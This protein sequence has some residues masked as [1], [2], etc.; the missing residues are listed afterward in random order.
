MRHLHGPTPPPSG[1]QGRQ[2]LGEKQ[3]LGW[4]H[5]PSQPSQSWW[6]PPLPGPGAGT[7]TPRGCSP[8]CWSCCLL[9]ALAL[10]VRA[11]MWFQLQARLRG[12]A[13]SSLFTLCPWQLASLSGLHL[14]LGSQGPQGRGLGPS[15]ESERLR[16][17]LPSPR[18]RQPSFLPLTPGAVAGG[19]WASADKGLAAWLRLIRSRTDPGGNRRAGIS[20]SNL[21]PRPRQSG[22]A[23]T[24]QGL[25]F[26][27]PITGGTLALQGPSPSAQLRVRCMQR[28]N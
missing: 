3:A 7:W 21:M 20:E 16:A 15:R 14:F 24:P 13:P 6:G 2:S 12:F 23:L 28:E 17:G 26:P 22:V 19:C 10:S 5:T 8:L 4:G 9:S 25:P 27:S 18:P 1:A 11:K